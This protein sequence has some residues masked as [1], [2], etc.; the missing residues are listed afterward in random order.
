KLST[1][2]FYRRLVRGTYTPMFR[3]ALWFGIAF[4]LLYTLTVSIFTLTVC[5]PMHA[6]WDV[7]NPKYDASNA[8]CQSKTTQIVVA[9]LDVVTD[10]YALVLPA[11]LLWQLQMNKRQRVGLL[12]V[13]SL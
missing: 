2:L 6:F 7:V 1:F 5:I 11:S 13:F 8:K 9:R 10:V 4:V 3:H 12:V